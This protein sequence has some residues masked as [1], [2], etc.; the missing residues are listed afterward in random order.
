MKVKIEGMTCGGCKKRVEEGLSKL[1][2]VNKVIVSLEDKEAHI[3]GSPNVEAV[4]E[5]VEDLGF[6]FISAQ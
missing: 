4:K 3:E 5:M 6:D 1:G 2:G